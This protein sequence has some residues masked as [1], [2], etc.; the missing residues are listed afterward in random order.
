MWDVNLQKWLK[1]N[2]P[3]LPQSCRVITQGQH[4]V[5]SCFKVYLKLTCTAHSWLFLSSH[6]EMWRI[7]FPMHSDASLL[8]S[9]HALT[10]TIYSPWLHLPA[11][12]LRGWRERNSYLFLTEG[13]GS[14]VWVQIWVTVCSPKVKLDWF[15]GEDAQCVKS[16]AWCVILQRVPT[17]LLSKIWQVG[18]ISAFTLTWWRE[19]SALGSAVQVS[20]TYLKNK[21][22]QFDKF[23]FVIFISFCLF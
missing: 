19:A 15:R 9:R 3:D 16:T 2:K 12:V 23:Y 1:M 21:Y 14:G 11:I 20:C 17:L 4:R 13:V 22:K 7:F 10:W 6:A 8:S 18:V 5:K